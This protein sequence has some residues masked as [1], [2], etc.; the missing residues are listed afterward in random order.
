MESPSIHNKL[1]LTIRW[2]LERCVGQTGGIPRLAFRSLC[3]QDSPTG[4]RFADYVSVF[5]AGV[6]VAATWDKKVAFDRGAAMG[7]EHK[8]KGVDI[9]LAV[10]AWFEVKRLRA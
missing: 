3:L 6:N 8:G 2:E 5:P 1:T 7:S 10:C 4:V 9:Q